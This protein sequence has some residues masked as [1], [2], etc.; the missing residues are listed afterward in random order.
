M[1]CQEKYED[2]YKK[3]MYFIQYVCEGSNV[4]SGKGEGSMNVFWL[5]YWID[6]AVEIWST[7]N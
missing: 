3:K 2:M 7:M 5:L 6:E 4:M 1:S